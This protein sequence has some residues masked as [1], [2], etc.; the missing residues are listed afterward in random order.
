MP[1]N[2]CMFMPCLRKD[3]NRACS[4]V[5]SQSCQAISTL[6]SCSERPALERQDLLCIY[7]AHHE[8]ESVNII[9]INDDH[10]AVKSCELQGQTSLA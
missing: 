3:S 2:K 1:I 9:M 5:S 10:H 4:C 7:L 6:Q 8:P